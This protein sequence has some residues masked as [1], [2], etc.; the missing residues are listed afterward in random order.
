MDTASVLVKGAEADA[1][2][3]GTF[4]GASGAGSAFVKSQVQLQRLQAAAAR[5]QAKALAVALSA[6]VGF[7]NAAMEPADRELVEGLF[8]SNDLAVSAA[9]GSG[10]VAYK[11]DKVLVQSHVHVVWL[12][13]HCM[14]EL[15]LYTCLPCWGNVCC[16][17]L[18]IDQLACPCCCRCFAQPPRWPWAS[19]FLHTWW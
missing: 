15:S 10:D 7:H 6:G 12:L 14:A 18:L 1:S 8:K 19:T 2:A 16:P 5:T 9:A 13:Q 4:S 17:V 11:G 3:R